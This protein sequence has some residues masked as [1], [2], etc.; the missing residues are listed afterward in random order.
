MLD[1]PPG[2]H[3]VEPTGDRRARPSAKAE[4]ESDDE[5]GHAERTHHGASD[6]EPPPAGA[7]T[8]FLDQRLEL[9]LRGLLLWRGFDDRHEMKLVVLAPSI[10]VKNPRARDAAGP[11]SPYR[12]QKRRGGIVGR[13]G[14]LVVLASL[15]LAF[16]AV[17]LTAFKA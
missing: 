4:D 15:A 13:L 3:D 2:T 5:A 11:P 7:L 6:D 17:A 1:R 8:R 12:G 9:V 10:D 16:V 14:S